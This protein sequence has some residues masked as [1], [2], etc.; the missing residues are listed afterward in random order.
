VCALCGEPAQDVRDE[1]G[2]EPLAT[3]RGHHADLVDPGA[4]HVDE[5][6][7]LV[8]VGGQ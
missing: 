8:D 2:H 7:R 6:H 4:E 1:V 3:V 5:A